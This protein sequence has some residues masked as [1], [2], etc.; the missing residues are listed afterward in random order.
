MRRSTLIA[1]LTVG[2][3]LVG[4]AAVLGVHAMT[5]GEDDL[6]TAAYLPLWD[7][8]P[9]TSLDRALDVG[10][11]DEVSPT[12]AFVQ[13]DGEL[14]LTPPPEPVQQMLEDSGAQ[15]IPVVQ[16][17][18]DGA[19]QGEMMAGLLADPE[20]EERHREA[21]IEVALDGGWDGIDID[22]ETLPPT[23]GPHF[24]D[25]LAR[26][27][28]DLHE[29]D[30]LLTVAVPA[31][32]SDDTPGALAYSYQMLGEVADEVRVMAYDHSWSGS[33]AGPVAPLPWVRDVV[34]YAV[35]R[36]PPE[37]LMLGLATY[38]YDWVGTSGENLGAQDAVA[39]ARA[40]DAE[41]VWDDE[42]AATRF[43]YTAGGEG[44]TVWFENARSLAAKQ[45]VAFEAGLRGVALWSLGG[46]DP[47]VWAE[48]G[49]AP[50]QDGDES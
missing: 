29:H 9:A 35:E 28:D 45:A 7:E 14:T 22:Y 30:L 31:R 20:R 27:R 49:V 12:W 25:F 10:E 44:H 13:P 33:E 38:G 47:Q 8:R 37:K 42:V 19:W 16:N 1:T 26:L 3:A 50:E 15:V 36:I 48:L 43:A 5:D 40:Q 17:F 21:L 39:L 2:A 41:L 18:S 4:G 24:N 23:A 11:L 6:V 46:E 34:D 32:T